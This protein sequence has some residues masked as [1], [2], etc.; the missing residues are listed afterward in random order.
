MGQKKKIK[1]L[2]WLYFDSWMPKG[3]MYLDIDQFQFVM[4]FLNLEFNQIRPVSH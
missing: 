1:W 3:E 2:K 4:L